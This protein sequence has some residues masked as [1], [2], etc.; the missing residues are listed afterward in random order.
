VDRGL[1]PLAFRYLILTSRYGRKLEYSDRSLAAA[2]AALGSLR[3]GLRALGAPPAEGPWV[4]PPVLVAGAAGD[5]PEGI[6]TGVAGHGG[7]GGPGFELT[8]RAGDPAAPLSP[9]GRALHQRYVAAL[10]DDLDM[11]IALALLREILGAPIPADERRW[12]VLDAD[13]VLGLDLHLAWASPT[14]DT[15]SAPDDI[16]TLVA[17][18]A[19]ARAQR[20]FARA[21]SLR[22]ELAGLGWE[23]VDG[24]NGST[25]RRLLSRDARAGPGAS[26]SGR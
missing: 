5:R 24:P 9:A 2:A 21:D 8:D 1:D 4:A 12:L 20:D 19:A 10:D 16:M 6:A 7:S 22:A 17:A 3:A 15:A 11:P 18:R 26:R 25:V 14:G 23:V 13:L